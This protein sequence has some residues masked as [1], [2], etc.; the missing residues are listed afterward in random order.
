MAKFCGNCG[1]G[2]EDDARVCGNCGTL[3]EGAGVVA[4]PSAK[5]RFMSIVIVAIVAVVAVLAVCLLSAF[6]VIGY[7]KAVKNYV[8]V[9]YKWEYSDERIAALA[10]KEYWDYL[11]DADGTEVD[12]V[13]DTLEDSADYWIDLYEDEYGDDLRVSYKIKDKDEIT[14]GKLKKIARALH[15][16]YDIKKSSVKKGFDIELEIAFKGSEDEDED[17]DEFAVI[18]IDDK[19]YPIWYSID[20]DECEYVY[21]RVDYILLRHAY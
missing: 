5:K 7:K 12:D 19:W 8:D 4:A 15:D 18:K 10:P 2:M 1:A 13:I 21:F 3:L 6:G 20:G 16:K 17:E 11:E 9:K 14:D